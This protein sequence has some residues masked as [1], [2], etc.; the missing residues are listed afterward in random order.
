M[1]AA[2][3]MEVRQVAQPVL[4][5][6]QTGSSESFAS[7]TPLA[8]TTPGNVVVYRVG[9]GTGSLTSA[10]T[11]VFLDEYTTT[12]TLVQ[13][14][15]MP[16]TAAVLGNRALTANGT[17]TAEGLLTRS[18]DGKYLVLTG[19][20]A[21]TGASAPNSSTSATVNRVIGR[22]D[23]FGTINTTTAQS[24]AYSAANIR[25]ATSSDGNTL[26]ETGSA[27]GVRTSTLGSTTSSLVSTTTTNLRQTAIFDGQLY[28]STAS[29][30]TFRIGKVGTGTPTGSGETITSLPGLPTS[31]GS[32]YGFF[33]ADLDATVIGNDTLYVADDSTAANGGGIQK[34]TFDGTTWTARGVIQSGATNLNLRGL[35]GVVNGPNSVALYTTGSSGTNGTLY[36]LTDTAGPAAN[37][38][39]TLTS[40]ATA[41]S[42]KAFRGVALAPLNTLV[43]NDVTATEGNA[44]TTNFNF[45]VSLSSPAPAGGVTFDIA[46]AD[47]TAQDDNPATED[48]DYEGQSLT[49]QTIPQG[50][51]SYNFTVQVNGDLVAETNETFFV[52]VTNIS[53][54]G[55]IAG[56]SQGLGT[57]QNEDSPPDLSID[58]VTQAETNGGTTIF[59]FNVSLT[60]PAPASGVTF[61][62]DTQDGTTDPATAGNDY[63]AIVGGFGSIPSGS[64]A[65][66]VNV[67]VNGD[68]FFEQ[69]ETFFVN[70][71]NVT[72]ANTIDTQGLGTIT[73]DDAQPTFSIADAFVTEGNAG[74]QQMT[75]TVTLTGLSQNTITVNYATADSSATVADAD[76]ISAGTTLTF[77]SG[78][79]SETFDVTINGDTNSEGDEM[80]LVNLS[81]ASGGATIGDSQALGILFL[82]DAFS[83]SAVNTPFTE[84]FSLLSPSAT[85]SATTPAAWTRAETGSNANQTYAAD[86]GFL[87]TGNTYS[88]GTTSDPDRALGQLQSGSL[89]PTIGAFFRND[90]GTTI[91]TLVV[92]YTGEQWRLGTTGR[93]D[94]LDFQYSTDA[95]GLTTGTWT[96]VNTLDFTAPVTSGSVGQLDGNLSANRTNISNLISGLSIAP[97]ATFWIR[98][99]DFNASGAD[100]GLAVD[101]FSITAN[102]VLPDTAPSVAST[103]PADNATDVASSANIGVTFN[104]AVSA[105]DAAFTINCV[106]S[107]A[108]TFV[109]STSDNITFTL[110][111]DSNFASNEV[112]TVTVEA[113][114]VTDSDTDDP[115][116]NMAADYTFD[117]TTA[118]F[119]ACGSTFT[120]IYTIQGS[121]LATP[122]PG[123]ATTEGIV[124]GDF[125]G[126]N[127]LKGFYIQDPTGD[128][129]TATSDGIFVFDGSS[130]AV[131]V[132]PGDRVRVSGTVS[133]AFNNTQI[134]PGSV[135]VCS[136][137]NPLPAPTVYDLPE[138]VN[139]D[140]ERVENMLVK[141][142]DTLTVTGNFTWG[143]FGEL[144]LS[145]DGRMFQ[146]NSFDRPNTTGALDRASLNLRSYIILDDG[147]STQNPNPIPY[148]SPDQTRRAGDTVTDLTGVLTFDFS[149]Y[150]LQPTVAP[151]FVQANPRPASPAGVGGTLR[152]ASSNVLN[153]FNGDGAGGGFPTSRGADTV[154]EF[155][156]QRAK[157]IAA[158]V[159][160]NA[161]VIGVS[162]M[163]NDGGGSSSALQDLVNGMNAATAPG[164]YIGLHSPNPGTDLIQNA[165]IYK[166]ASV[167]PLGPQVNDINSAWD[168]AR[169]PLAQLFQQN[170]NSEKFT[171]IVNHFT[172]KGCS[173]SDTGIDQDFG[174][175][176]GCDNGQRQIQANRLLVFIQDRKL[177]ANDPDVLSV[178]D[179]NAYGE[180]DPLFILEQDASDT[181]ADGAGGLVSESEHFVPA[182]D[183][184]SF[185]FGNQFGELDHAFTTKSLSF[186][187]SGATIWH[188]N[189]DEPVAIDYNQEFKTQDLYTPTAFRAADHDPLLIGLNLTST[190][191]QAAGSLIIS[192]FRFRGPG[193]SQDE[194][195]ELYNNTSGDITVATTDGSLGWTVV[196]SNGS[197]VCRVDNGRTIPARGHF[198]C[199]NLAGYSLGGYATADT[200]WTGGDVPDSAGIAL[201]RSN[202]PANYNL[203]N[204]LD[205]V[206]YANVNS[207]YREGAG[208]Q[209]SSP[210]NEIGGNI[211]Y[212]FLR[213]MTRASNGLPKDT[214]DNVA[215]FM[216]VDTSATTSTSI[217]RNLGAPGPENLASPINRNAQ[218]GAAL[219]DPTVSS[220]ASPNRVRSFSPVT[221]G[222]FGTLSIRRTFTNNTGMPIT[223]LRF[224]IVEITTRT[225]PVVS[226]QADLRAL[227]SMLPSFVVMTGGGP[228][229]VM[230]TAVEDNPPTQ[231]SGGG[232]NSSLN[233]PSVGGSLIT[234]PTGVIL[235][236]TPLLPGQS[237]SVEFLLGVETPGT[238]VFYVNIEAGGGCTIMVLEPCALTKPMIAK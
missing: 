186:Q 71:T 11:A 43:I 206:G 108:H 66:T 72:G 7:P 96:D 73:N 201:F 126:A 135:Q 237:I 174:D 150:R 125:Q 184:Y 136:T 120:P 42:N 34:F 17:S 148:Q 145:S 131:D 68:A 158:L 122:I 119:T 217:G 193:G 138:P 5:S 37:I 36:S 171:F 99:N 19:Y 140:L 78:D 70:L 27:E 75:F 181:L 175:G 200:T 235:L 213:T 28:V 209:T 26:W 220:T 25:S 177:A 80:F 35:T 90:T 45:T 76:Y 143:R 81:S 40:I 190:P 167:T 226:G 128:A 113:A 33:F 154:A 192:E 124:I 114:Q 31:T 95:T 100:D 20:N 83:L 236:G 219:L 121:G 204:R 228:V 118:T 103:V 164:T 109:S 107:G 153:Y 132:N 218:F 21:T 205:A 44:G 224:R 227:D 48:N 22:V 222:A 137:G 151:V 84:N 55:V 52:N 142:T 62:V 86:N 15:A 144:A 115:P 149:E 230:A 129:N 102:A 141:F 207:L 203:A 12:G 91:T 98:Y 194:F 29:G 238:F 157:I 223:R 97:G 18:A 10:A 67:T 162:E 104:E 212:A 127:G 89:V 168:Q 77:V 60:A 58:N 46:T 233:V 197:A 63:V 50:G 69:N 185:Q 179:Y 8:P 178:G 111:P 116:Q 117:F 199:A 54:T 146:Q 159:A 110:N 101:D 85:A 39:G 139:N 182:T 53:G 92:S 183:R 4:A 161:D 196:A 32:P 59:T 79:T 172:S 208:F 187:V 105:P 176:Q 87:G 16:T 166:P 234:S 64:S 165:I 13:S 41:S 160:L 130:P 180:E 24:D 61:Q 202:N 65:T 221:N 210:G 56:D 123:A 170:S 51:T 3:R 57:I 93:T 231:A 49:A 88:Y 215:D 14:I 106:S 169:P 1:L 30:T 112:C 82:D 152:V 191:P 195:V 225:A 216:G 9:T 2:K 198:L 211:E 155:N 232:W 156:R 163:E 6:S 189:A 134:A 229:N 147:L 23:A 214:G 94:R 188:I 47:G 38:N 133:E 173:A 74:T